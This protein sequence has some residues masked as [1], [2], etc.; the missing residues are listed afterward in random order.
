MSL[1]ISHDEGCPGD[2]T[3]EC[4]HLKRHSAALD[5]DVDA[6]RSILAERDALAARVAEVERELAGIRC[7]ADES[8]ERVRRTTIE[9]ERGPAYMALVKIRNLAAPVPEATPAAKD[10]TP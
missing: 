5:V 3:C 2:D 10:G 8:M 9:P 4:A 7:V 1:D 6:G